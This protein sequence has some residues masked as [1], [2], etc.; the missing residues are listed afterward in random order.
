MLTQSPVT[1]CGLILLVGQLFTVLKAKWILLGAIFFFELGSL[2][3]AVAQSMSIL[4][5]ARAIQGIG[6]SL[7][8]LQ[9]HGNIR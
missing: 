6:T 7:L 8:Q 4:I 9:Y 2:I 5:F 3:C 1:Q